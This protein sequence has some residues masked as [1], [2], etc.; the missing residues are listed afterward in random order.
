MRERVAKEV[1]MPS[2]RTAFPRRTFLAAGA[3]T[4]TVLAVPSRLRAQ[5]GEPVLIGV[6]GPLTGQYAQYGAQWKKG[7]D[8]AL[9]EINASGGI[10]GRSLKYVFEDS[11]AIL[12]RRW[13]L[14]ANSWPTTRSSW[15]SAI[16][17]AQPRWLPRRSTRQQAWCSSALRTRIHISPRAATSSGAMPLIRSRRDA[18]PR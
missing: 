2:H 7:F 17:R 5:S 1:S 10:N 13:P 3:A 12:A 16:S 4:L 15:R 6:C 9:D 11:Q 18:A 14:R 8:F